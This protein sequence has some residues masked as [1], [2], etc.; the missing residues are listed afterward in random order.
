M[1][2]LIL[3]LAACTA[4]P[5][6]LYSVPVTADPVDGASWTTADGVAI[7]L[8][9]ATLTFA[10]LRLYTPPAAI[11]AWP[12][13]VPTAYG[14]PGAALRGET[15]GE[16]LGTW[17]VDLLDGPVQLGSASCYLGAFATASLQLTG[18]LTSHGTATPAG[19]EPVAF[20]FDASLSDSAED[21][22]FE[23]TLTPDSALTLSIHSASLLRHVDWSTAKVESALTLNDGALATTVAFGARSADT[24]TLAVTP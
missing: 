18:A 5:P 7:T 17:T 15:A 23:T 1:R 6:R 13:L 12:S 22:F 20:T 19:G 10:D 8:T 9:E 11:V 2:W 4:E 14:H 16:L 24:W 3:S 21:L